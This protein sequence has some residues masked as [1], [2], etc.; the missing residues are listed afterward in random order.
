[1]LG[2]LAGEL[3][4]LPN[5]LLIEGHTDAT[6]Y[7]SDASYS[8]WELS[9]DRANSARRLLQQDGVRG[10]QVTQVRGYADQLLRV[11]TNPYD[12]SNRRVSI[13][14]KNDN[15]VPAK[16]SGGEPIKAPGPAAQGKPEGSGKPASAPPAA[17]AAPPAA[18]AV[19][20][21][22]ASSKPTAGAPAAKPG[23]MER[24]KGMLP[25]SKK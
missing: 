25:G 3:K 6:K 18:P 8:N 19:T 7:S 1:L 4:T 24:L 2:L 21:P 16:I 23:L 11:K 5:E 9:A 15:G 13:L 10:N 14:V 12:P 20:K 17:Q 22:Q